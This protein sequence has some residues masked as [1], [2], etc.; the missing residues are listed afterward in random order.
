MSMNYGQLPIPGA[1]AGGISPGPM[2]GQ[3]YVPGAG[4]VEVKDWTQEPVYDTELLVTPIA[5]GTTYTFFRNLNIAA[6]PKDARYTNMVTTQQLPSGWRAI[7]HG[8]HF[9]VLPMEVAGAGIPTTPEDMQRIT[10]QGVVEFV[11]GNSKIE[12]QGPMD[13]FPDPYGLSGPMAFAGGV[14]HEFSNL[15]NGVPSLGA[16]Q[17]DDI[18]IDLTNELTFF[19]TATF[20]GGLVLDNN[21]FLRCTLRAFVSKPV[22]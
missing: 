16:M 8:V 1:G 4:L 7:V 2:P 21:C 13:M 14:L 15:S 3:I 18:V 19:A 11:T 22:R 17:K 20:P 6:V 10:Y 12:R 9:K 5:A